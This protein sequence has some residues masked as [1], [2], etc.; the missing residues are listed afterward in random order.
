MN[1][2]IPYYI[3]LKKIKRLRI[4]GLTFEKI[5]IKFGCSGSWINSILKFE[6]PCYQKNN[7]NHNC[8]FVNR[9]NNNERT[10]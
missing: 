7:H 10:I 8:H 4:K 5:G 2:Y 3:T 6:K 9:K 1:N